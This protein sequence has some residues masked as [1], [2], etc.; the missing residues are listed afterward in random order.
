MRGLQMTLGGITSF[1]DRTQSVWE[2]Q[3]ES[4]ITSYYESNISGGSFQTVITVT[5]HQPSWTTSQRN[6]LMRGQRGLQ[7]QDNSIVITYNQVVRTDDDNLSE[8]FLAK[9][10]FSS[11]EQRDEYVLLLQ[12]SNDPELELVTDSS[13][14][15]FADDNVPTSAPRPTQ[16]PAP[17]KE[18]V[19]SMAAIIGIA[20]G[21]GAL[22]IIGVLSF[23]YCKKKGSKDKSNMEG[24]PMPRN[25]SVKEDE[26]STLAGP[27]ITGGGVL[28]DRR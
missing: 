24:D 25:V 21:G 6:R 9:A 20:C 3:T 27:S 15:T 28:G 16:A 26:I 23:I 19:L 17:S 2:D 11:P 5:N 8:D 1:S 10:P 14:V 22:I 12:N 13:G 4:F 18:P 7:Q